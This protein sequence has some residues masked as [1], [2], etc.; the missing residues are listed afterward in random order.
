LL[1]LTELTIQY[2]AARGVRRRTLPP[3][4]VNQVSFAIG[5]G[6]FVALVGESGSGKTSIANAVLG[7][8]PISSGSI[9]L[10]GVEL[11]GLSRRSARSARRAAQLIMQ[12]P[13][14]ALDPLFTVRA[15]VEEPLLVHE[16]KLGKD[17]RRG[18]VDAALTA[19]GLEPVEEF[20]E[21]RPH[22]LSGGQRQRVSVAAALIVEPGL[23]IADE[24]V[25]MLDVSVRAGIL[26][27]LD[28]IRLERQ[29]GIM[30]ITHDLP[31]ALAFCERV[32]VMRAGEI[33]ADGTPRQI[34]A[35]EHPYT[36]ALLDATPGR[37][38]TSDTARRSEGSNSSPD[39]AAELDVTSSERRSLGAAGWSGSPATNTGLTN[40]IDK[41]D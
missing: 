10:A 7:L 21:R 3:A 2:H 9:R 40:I 6:S 22:E 19:V 23:L 5:A 8:A 31:T 4:A 1:E 37:Q 32:L 15:L 28:R 24:P 29:M 27:L 39:K 12:D 38:T 41:V 35:G 16:P 34:R 33:V 14:D 20:A 13:F 25:S 18:R 30:M 11:A 36:R 26:H 17:A